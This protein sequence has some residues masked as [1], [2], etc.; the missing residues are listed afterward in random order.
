MSGG[1]ART[2]LRTATGGGASGGG[3]TQLW[4]SQGSFGAIIQPLLL[5][6]AHDKRGHSKDGTVDV[7]RRRRRWRR[8]N[9]IVDV[10]GELWCN[11]STAIIGPLLGAGRMASL[12]PPTGSSGAFFAVL[13]AATILQA[14]TVEDNEDN[15]ACAEDTR[16]EWGR[17]EDASRDRRRQQEEAPVE[18]GQ[19]DC[20]HRGGAAAR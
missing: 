1:A 3:T 15:C 7:D 17:R 6:H 18:E 9:L 12:S 19:P 13:P 14:N 16:D 11:N 2:G 8:D 10:V 20:G 5:A 4:M